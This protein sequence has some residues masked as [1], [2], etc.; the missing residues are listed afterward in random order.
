MGVIAKLILQFIAVSII[1]AIGIFF[2]HALASSL[3]WLEAILATMADNAEPTGTLKLI[4]QFAGAGFV[5]LMAII[6]IGTGFA[7]RQFVSQTFFRWR[8]IVTAGLIP[9]LAHAVKWGLGLYWPT[10]LVPIQQLADQLI[11]WFAPATQVTL[12]LFQARDHL[13][14]LII[15]IALMILWSTIDFIGRYLTRRLK[16]RAVSSSTEPLAQSS[17]KWS[18]PM[19]KLMRGLWRLVSFPI[20]KV[21]ELLTEDIILN[22]ISWSAILIGIAALVAIGISFGLLLL[23]NWAVQNQYLTQNPFTGW[24]QSLIAGLLITTF[25]QPEFDESNNIKIFTVPGP[26]LGAQVTW[27][28][29]VTPFV[30]E[31]GSYPTLGRWLGF[32]WLQIEP[33]VRDG[34]ETSRTVANKDGFIILGDITF[35][36]WNSAGAETKAEQTTITLPAKNTAPVSGSL[37]FVLKGLRRIR[38][39]RASDTG[40]ELGNRARQELQEILEWFVD[41]DV[42]SMVGHM[43][44]LFKGSVL[45]TA[46]MPKDVGRWKAGSMIRNEQGKPLFRI[47]SDPTEETVNAAIA[48]FIKEDLATSADPEM[49]AAITK[50]KKRDESTEIQVT[51]FRAENS[52]LDVIT[53]RGFELIRVM[54]DS[55]RMSEE[56]EN[57]AKQASSE[58]DE[59]IS[60]LASARANAEARKIL[61]PSE[62]EMKNPEAWQFATALQAANDSK[63]GGVRIVMI[64]GAGQLTREMLGA[65]VATE[66]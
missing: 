42:K 57:A 35:Q 59:R 40:L 13:M 27:I 26:S 60:Q 45:V 6:I 58:A 37:S 49:L 53:E 66:R 65:N 34:K 19:K 64:P 55:V 46:M 62:E 4:L 61:L 25:L 48:A 23:G 38:W 28:G 10:L 30:L 9:L 33:A 17:N 29:T 3:N 8:H 52:I 16:A 47:V 21:K 56:V 31:T 22:P 11:S 44:E 39:V 12:G 14:T 7:M 2:P 18:T 1:M 54:F 41:T 20:R 63:N 15:G 43:L 32:G 5:V 51:S 24:V 50:S 36:V